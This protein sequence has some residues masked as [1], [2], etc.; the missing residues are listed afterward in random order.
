MELTV[1]Q[2]EPYALDQEVTVER[3]MKALVKYLSD[4]NL[5]YIHGSTSLIIIPQYSF[6]MIEGIITNFHQPGSTLLLLVSA[7]MGQNWKE[8][9]SF[10]LE[11][12]FR[13]LSY[14]DSSLLLR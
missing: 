14:G 8:A 7:W 6:R 5:K 1:G 9:Y 13:F 10:A 2:W 11:N 4:N 3:S 12:E